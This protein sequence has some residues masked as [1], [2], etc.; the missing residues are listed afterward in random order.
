MTI[1]DY[2]D[3]VESVGVIVTSI[4]A[5]WGIDSWRREAKWK[6]R[7]ELSE[8]VLYLFYS[9]AE[10]IKRI[11]SPYSSINEGST[12]EKAPNEREEI[13]ELLNRAYVVYER[14]EKE[15]DVFIQ[16]SKLKYKFRAAFG[17]ESIVP[18]EDLDNVLKDIFL[19][20][21]K[22][23][24]VYWPRQGTKMSDDEINRH[25]KKMRD[26]QAIF[27]LNMV[28]PDPIEKRVNQIIENI[29]KIC[30]KK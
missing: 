9:S 5:I 22:L 27:W 8:E 3:I 2:F 1:K 23:G 20:A 29:E 28:D 12:R 4:V 18:F 24:N 19:A 25:L 30:E 14:Y 6:R 21:H 26:N 11:R 10:S 15:K 16:L 17:Q 7:Y 13:T